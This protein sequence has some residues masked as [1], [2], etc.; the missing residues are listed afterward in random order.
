MIISKKKTIYSRVSLVFFLTLS[1]VSAQSNRW[2][3]CTPN[4]AWCGENNNIIKC[5]N[6]GEEYSV[7]K[8]CST[9]E[10]CVIREAEPKCV[11]A[12][13]K[14]NIYLYLLGGIILLFLLI[15]II[16]LTRPKRKR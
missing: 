10:I 5:D 6:T 3:V 7:I 8:E 1:F 14:T 15:L 13:E 12:K 9:G 2:E 4:I 11:I 16:L